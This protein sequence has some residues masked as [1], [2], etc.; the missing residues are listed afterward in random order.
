MEHSRNNKRPRGVELFFI[1]P[2]IVGG[3]P[4]SAD[5]IAYLSRR[6]HIEAVRYWNKTINNL[7]KQQSK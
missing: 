3:N 5:N 1:T 7:R 4:N 2:I 6:Q